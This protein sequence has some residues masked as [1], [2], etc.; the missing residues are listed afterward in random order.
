MNFNSLA[1]FY[2]QTTITTTKME[3]KKQTKS[4]PLFINIFI[5]YLFLY[6]ILTILTNNRQTKSYLNLSS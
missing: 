3:E 2:R 4:I 6:S 5:L 1:T